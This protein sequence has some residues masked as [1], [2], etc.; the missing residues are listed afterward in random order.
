[1][2]TPAHDTCCHRA[3]LGHS[4]KQGHLYS[5]AEGLC[6]VGFLLVL[7]KLGW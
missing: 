1:M 2:L 3:G 7:A 6:K 4:W 5:E